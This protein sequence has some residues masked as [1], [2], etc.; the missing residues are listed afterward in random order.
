MSTGRG[1]LSLPWGDANSGGA[2]IGHDSNGRTVRYDVAGLLGAGPAAMAAAA[3]FAA[4]ASAISAPTA[5]VQMAAE[6]RRLAA[7]TGVEPDMVMSPIAGAYWARDVGSISGDLAAWCAGMGGAF[8]RTSAA[9]YFGP[10]ALMLPAAAGVPRLQ[11]DPV[12][13]DRQGLLTE[14]GATNS[15]LR[16]HDISASPWVLS[17]SGISISGT[18]VTAPDGGAAKVVN[19][20][21]SLNANVAQPGILGTANTTYTFSVWLCLV[22]GGETVTTSSVRFYTRDAAGAVK[23][24]GLSAPVTLQKGVWQ[25]VSITATNDAAGTM[26]ITPIYDLAGYSIAIWGAQVEVGSLATSL[27][28]T[29]TAAASRAADTVSIATAGWLRPTGDGTLFTE[30]QV[31]GA[32]PSPLVRLQVGLV[33]GSDV[34]AERLITTFGAL[35]A[36]ADTYALKSGAAAGDNNNRVI[37]LGSPARIAGRLSRTGAAQS[38]NGSAVDALS[39]GSSLSPLTT[40]T[41]G[42]NGATLR[43]V[44]YWR[45][46]LTDAQL[47]SLSATTW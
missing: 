39:W 23:G 14:A 44:A 30:A 33:A 31:D 45:T 40:L 22:D 18:T 6:Q 25:R 3:N 13:G 2:A 9:T 11:C 46:P 42:T 37:S 10:S 15:A 19:I 1:L 38:V 47:Q 27:I 20:T 43:R 4:T 34:W 29:T 8:T 7:V 36:Y 26:T 35:P 16:S 24:T 5:A 12:T 21:A 41:I 32:T 17:A 28:P